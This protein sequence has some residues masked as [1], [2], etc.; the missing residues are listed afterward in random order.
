MVDEVT[1]IFYQNVVTQDI[2]NLVQRC[3]ARNI[4]VVRKANAG[5]QGLVCPRLGKSPISISLRVDPN[6]TIR[7]VKYQGDYTT[8]PNDHVAC[9][10]LC[11]LARGRHVSQVIGFT[12][13]EFSQ[14]L[15]GDSDDTWEHFERALKIVEDALT[16]RG[17]RE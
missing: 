5:A 15:G 12:R 6:G 13:S 16:R 11:D 9:W 4:G 17:G 10:I 3:K 2:E 7:D 8:D 1:V 14:R